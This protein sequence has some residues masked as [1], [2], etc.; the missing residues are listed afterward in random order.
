MTQVALTPLDRIAARRFEWQEL[1]ARANQL[2]PE[3]NDWSTFLALAGRGFGKTRLAAEWL[4]WQAIRTRNG[5][6]AIVAPTHA[7]A[8]DTCAEGPSGI[9]NILTEYGVLQ[10]YNRSMGEISL[11]NKAKIKLYSAEEPDRLRGPNFHAG[12]FDELAASNAEAWD[13][14]KFALR[15]GSH[16]QTIVTTTPRPTKLIKELLKAD[17]TLTVRGST[18][19]NAANLAP[20]ALAEL[21]LKYEGTRLGQQELYGMVL[22][23]TEGALFSPA[24]LERDRVKEA[25]PFIRI[26]VGV[27]PAVTSGEEADETGI[28]VAGLTSDGHYYVLDDV[29]CRKSPDAWARVAVDAY[30]KWKADRIVAETNNGG[31]MIEILLRQV[32]PNVSYRKVTAT[33]GKVVRAE[34]VASLSEQGRLHLV[35]LFPALEDQLCNFTADTTVSPNNFDAMVWA[36]S[37]LMSNAGAM[38]SLSK[39]A[40][41]CS[42]CRMPASKSATVC[43]HCQN[44]LGD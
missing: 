38:L 7:M 41:F 13:Q 9:V 1:Q 37:E 21:R 22:E 27:D 4:A 42:K 23:E 31:D 2:P 8:R 12:W 40:Q 26:V 28:V 25:P 39:L 29:T 16:P 20:S 18:F 17:G 43:P 6:F 33:R 19:D 34:P 11:T 44:P 15:L 5:R 24:F 14:Y 35:G 30:H 32:D 36:V 10:Q 3:G